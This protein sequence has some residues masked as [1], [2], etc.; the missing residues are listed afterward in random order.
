MS[1]QLLDD[2]DIIITKKH[3]HDLLLYLGLH[4]FVIKLY[5]SR[6]LSILAHVHTFYA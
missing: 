1:R 6:W 3:H 2:N 5:V 4:S